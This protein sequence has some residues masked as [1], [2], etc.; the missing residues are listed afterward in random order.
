[1]TVNSKVCIKDNFK[2][3]RLINWRKNGIKKIHHTKKSFMTKKNQN[4][5]DK[6]HAKKEEKIS[7]SF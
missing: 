4:L 1:M 2:I 5:L 6:M 7:C 3:K